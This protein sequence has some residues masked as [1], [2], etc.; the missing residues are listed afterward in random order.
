ML[1]AVVVGAGQ[2]ARKVYLPV[3][4][5]MEDVEPAVLVEPRAERRQA[6][7]RKYRFASA[8]ASAEEIAGAAIIRFDSGALGVF[9][10]SRHFGWRK[11]ELEIHGENF[12]FHVLAP[13]RAR[14]YQAGRELIYRHGHDTWYAQSEHR[15]GF[16]EEIRHFLDALRDRSEPINSARDALKSHRLAHDILAKLRTAHG[17]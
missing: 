11:D 12:T 10:T 15:Y 1:R 6:L 3:L 14:L 4:A 17:R 5:A 8:A 7:C 16:A 2:M 13:Q 9:E